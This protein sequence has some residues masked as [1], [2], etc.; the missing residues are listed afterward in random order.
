VSPEATPPVL[1]VLGSGTL[2][3][4]PLR[5]SAAHHLS[6]PSGARILL[7]CGPGTVHGFGLHGIAWQEITH[8]AI[9]HFHNDHVGDLSALLMAFRNGLETPRTDPLTLL[10]PPGFQGF[11]ER[12][13]AALGRH[14]LDPGFE[15]RTV[16][17]VP[18]TP[19]DDGTGFALSACATPHTAESLAYRI[20]GPWGAVGYTGDTGPDP[21][22]F[23]FLAGCDVLVSECD[24]PDHERVR[25]HL[26][27]RGLRELVE[28]AAPGLL[29]VVHVGRG[30]VP[31]EVV[32]GMEAEGFTN[33]VD[34][35]DGMHIELSHLGARWT[36]T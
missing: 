28:L 17:V 25:T 27:P 8:V 15:V 14:V 18:G 9:T 34:G 4:D 21:A 11:L 19:F 30:L 29:V 22:L 20:T 12:L 23:R 5:H 33:V 16:E 35:R 3:P 31:A 36:Q 7:D 26:S 2:V 13:A 6:L 24:V 10:G 32:R 1:T